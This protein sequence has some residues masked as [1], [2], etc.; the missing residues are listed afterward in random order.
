MC[1]KTHKVEQRSG[2]KFRASG[3]TLEVVQ[4]TVGFLQSFGFDPHLIDI[5]KDFIQPPV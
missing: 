5:T 1:F 3:T 4:L 2:R